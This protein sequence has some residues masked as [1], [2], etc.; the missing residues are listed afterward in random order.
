MPSPPITSYWWEEVINFYV[1][2]PISGLFVEES[3]FDG[4][5]F[6]MIKHIDK[7]FNPSITVD[8]LS[9]IFNLINVKQASD[10]SVITL[11]VRFSRFFA[12]LKLGGIAIDSALQVGFMLRALLLRYHGVVQD[13]CLGHHSLASATL[14]SV[15]E[16]CMAYDKDPWK[17]PVGKDG[18]PVR[19]LS[20]YTVGASG[21]SSNPYKSLTTCSFS[22]HMSCL[23]ASCKDGSERC[24]LCHITSN[25]PAHH[26]KDCPIL[27]KIGLKLVKPTPAD[28]GDA[29]SQVGHE[30]PLPAP[31]TAPPTAPNPPA[32]NG[33]SA[34]MPGAFT[35][36]GSAGMPGAFTAATEPNSYNLGD[37]FDYEGKYEGKVDSNGNS[38]SNVPLL[39]MHLSC[40]RRHL[41]P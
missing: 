34:G 27:K 13:F 30:A 14:Q 20:A 2:P 19:T 24:M 6:E 33:G 1:K 22:N 38:K 32:N 36:G 23:Q 10:E 15:V 35:A 4:K 21:D 26:S 16:Q 41:E 39:P 37:D 18:K 40:L 28:G 31:P 5:G 17:G 7:Y 12:F 25:K 29:A 8:S 3:Q 11:K 9:Y